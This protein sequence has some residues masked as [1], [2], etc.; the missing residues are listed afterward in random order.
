MTELFMHAKFNLRIWVRLRNND[1]ERVLWKGGVARPKKQS[2][3]KVIRSK[4]EF[5]K[6]ISI[7]VQTWNSFLCKYN[8]LTKVCLF[9][10]FFFNCFNYFLKRIRC[11]DFFTVQVI[12]FPVKLYSFWIFLSVY[13]NTG[14]S[15]HPRTYNNF[16]HNPLFNLQ[17]IRNV[18]LICFINLNL[19]YIKEPLL[20]Y[21]TGK[22]N[23]VFYSVLQ[24][25]CLENR[26]KKSDR[27]RYVIV[28]CRSLA[29]TL[30]SLVAFM[31]VLSAV[32][33]PKWLVGPPKTKGW[34]NYLI[35][36]KYYILQENYYH[37]YLLHSMSL[38]KTRTTQI[39]FQN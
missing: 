13:K 19:N 36:L 16:T 4:E 25:W 18:I 24:I 9:I 26:K 1:T 20:V 10:Y 11:N 14:L 2:Q 35:Q 3:I 37:W 17:K 15:W 28:T 6:Y 27:M 22:R 33:T 32:I 12:R 8:L 39:I 30:L 23:V 31:A 29:W 34:S 38:M 5:H 7:Q 21:F